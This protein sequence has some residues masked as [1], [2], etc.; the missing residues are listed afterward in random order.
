MLKIFLA[1]FSLLYAILSKFR[2]FLYN[3][4]LIKSHFF[5][6]GTVIA[7]GNLAVGGT[8]KTPHSE[9]LASFL[10]SKYNT[11]MLSRG[12]KRK[13]KGFLYV[14]TEENY[15]N[16]GDEAF[17]I[18]S[19]FD[20]LIVAV[21]EN[22]VEGVKK[23]QAEQKTEIVIL[24]DA[25]Q[26]RKIKPNLNILL[27]EFRNPFFNDNFLP[28]GKLRDNKA[29]YTRAEIII[30]TNCPD[31][32]KPIQKT[33]WRDDLK[34]K[35]YQK[36]FFTKVKYTSIKNIKSKQITNKE[37]FTNHQ[38]LIVSGIANPAYFYEYVN[39][40]I[41]SS[42]A[43]I[44]FPDHKNFTSK[45]ILKIKQKFNS[46]PETKKI[47]LTTEKDAVRLKNNLPPELY[48]F[49]FYQEIKIE[50]LFN[51]KEKFEELI[52]QTLEN[53]NISII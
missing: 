12:Y 40:N 2:N 53:K 4:K 41:S 36:H 45:D 25:L 3:H 28:L 44:N 18:K 21:C 37:D 7:L 51:M 17:Q 35:P 46:L 1:P 34:L 50:F 13:T 20:N 24:D 39:N 31:D 43:Q 6:K 14:N 8:G 49:V 47:I 23:L 48:D 19:K 22:R 15:K 42:T 29:E 9:Y 30:I 38:I 10:N 5:H 16:F 33:I 52:L 11:A 27:T 26:H 32:L